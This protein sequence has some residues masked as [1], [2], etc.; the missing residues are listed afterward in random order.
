M[1]LSLELRDQLHDVAVD[2]SAWPRLLHS[3][4]DLLGANE[5]T[6]GGGPQWDA[7]RIYAPRTDPGYVGVYLDTYHDQNAFMQ[8]M[9]R[10]SMGRVVA[11]STL[12]GFEAFQRSDFYNLWCVPQRFTHSFCFSITTVADWAGTMSINVSSEPGA[13]Q[14]AALATLMPHVQRAMETHLLLEQLRA[15]HRSTLSVLNLAGNGALLLDRQGR[16]LEANSIAEAILQ[17]GQLVL[18]DGRLRGPDSDSDQDLT[19]LLSQCLLSPDQAGARGQVSVGALSVQCAPFSA[20]QLFPQPQRP[21]AVVIIA[22]PHQK[23]R[24][25]LAEMQQTFGLTQAEAELAQAVVLAGSRKIAAEMRGVTD[26]TA[27]AQLS[28]I[29]D[30]TGVRRQTDLVRL[31]MGGR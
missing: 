15:S 16:V 23:L 3:L 6:F 27:R 14:M 17:S 19:R 28:S 24:Q 26:A 18:R 7:P 8:S 30:K 13:D 10:S 12:P 9:A 2:Q 11:A 4:A 31:L 22:D 25:R 29:F 1:E 5:A 21:A 20:S